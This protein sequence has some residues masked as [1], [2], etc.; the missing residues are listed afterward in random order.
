MALTKD[1]DQ[2]KLISWLD[3]WLGIG[4]N[5]KLRASPLRMWRDGTGGGP[6]LVQSAREIGRQIGKDKRQVHRI[7]ER[8]RR[9]NLL[10]ATPASRDGATIGYALRLRWDS[11]EHAINHINQDESI[12]GEDW[13]DRDP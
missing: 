13:D 9:K 1:D 12:H 4:K 5:G 7:I 8:L 10:E 11:I 2:Q 6:W 3:Y